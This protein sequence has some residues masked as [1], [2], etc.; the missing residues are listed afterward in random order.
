MKKRH[1]ILG[2]LA[3]VLVLCSTIGMSFAYFTTYATS[4]GGYVIK[5]QPRIDEKFENKKKTIW[6]TNSENASPIFVRA[7]VFSGSDF[8]INYEPGADWT[9][10]T[11]D[12]YWYYTKPLQG[13]E[14]TTD[15]VASIDKIPEGLING[16][17]FNIVVVY[18]SVLAVYNGNDP[19][20]A[21]SW[22]N[23]TVKRVPA[24]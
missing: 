10:D 4:Q 17:E 18:E 8:T 6:I 3:I 12:H 23:G 14:P 15:L 11:D 5:S 19:D 7:K 20:M 16:D 13:G 22:A 2:V 21:T 9:Y 1:I 24:P